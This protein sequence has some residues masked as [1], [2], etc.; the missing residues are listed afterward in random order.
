MDRSRP[1]FC[2]RTQALNCKTGTYDKEG[3]DF[4]TETMPEDCI[5]SRCIFLDASLMKTDFIRSLARH[6]LPGML[7][8]LTV[9]CLAVRVTVRDAYPWSAVFFYVGPW[10]VLGVAWVVLGVWCWRLRRAVPVAAA[11]LACTLAGWYFA[12]GA[13]ARQAAGA[14]AGPARQVLFWNIGHPEEIPPAVHALVGQYQPDLVVL[15]E[16]EKIRAPARQDFVI[17]HPDYQIYRLFGGMLV[18]LRGTAVLG[19]HLDL[20]HSSRAHALQ[21]QFR[22]DPDP[23]ELVVADLGP[24]PLTPRLERTEAIRHLAG[25]GRRTL[26]IGDFNTP[27]DA[28]AFDPWRAHWHHGLSQVPQSPGA[29]TWPLGLPLLS[30]DHVWM[31]LDCQPLQAVKGFHLPF[32]HSWQIITL[33]PTSG[34][35]G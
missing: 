6:G 16:S 25:T 26:V 10:P 18:A 29:T 23:W 3:F 32:D 33:Q 31:S 1:L 15:A 27:Y 22:N 35:D 2:P 9:V 11:G 30:L 19:T 5:T 21:L 28:T 13:P 8:G 20:P 17:R 12:P 14:V 4:F 24:M 34:Q 7:G